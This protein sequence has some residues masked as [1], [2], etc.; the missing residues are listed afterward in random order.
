MI[1]ECETLLALATVDEDALDDTL[2]AAWRA[3]DRRAGEIL[4]E[5]YYT[6]VHRFF[7]NKVSEPKELTQRTF[8]ACLES[9]HRYCEGRS[10]RAYLLGI[11]YNVLRNHFREL[12][13]SRSPLPFD[14]TSIPDSGWTPSEAMDLDD[15]KRRV[16]IALQQLPVERQTALELHMW[17]ELTTREIAHLLG[18]PL[19]TVKDRLRR[20]KHELQERIQAQTG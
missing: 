11:A 12:H 18:W 16:R 14:A 20:A 6:R 10:F 5:R 15:Q 9:V 3:A 19:G 13:D 17:E 4:F 1:D 8:L 7:A 2:L